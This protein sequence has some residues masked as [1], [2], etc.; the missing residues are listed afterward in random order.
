MDRDATGLYTELSLAY[1]DFS[2]LIHQL[3]PDKRLQSGVS[4]HWSPKDVISHLIGWDTALQ[5]FIADPD[6]FNPDPLYDI[7][8]FNATSVSARQH[9]SWEETIDELQNSYISLQKSITTV[10]ADMKIYVRVS[11]WLKGRIEDY[12]FHTHQMETWITH[13]GVVL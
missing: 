2:R 3:E 1:S 4:G 5:E 12:Q 10:T 6:G 11:A 8:T 9:K 13:N 7:H